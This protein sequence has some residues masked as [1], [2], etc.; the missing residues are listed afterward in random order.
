MSTETSLVAWTLAPNQLIAAEV[1]GRGGTRKEAAAAASVI[2][3]T[4]YNWLLEAEFQDAVS[5][6]FRE[7]RAEIAAKRERLIDRAMEIERESLAA[8]SKLSPEQRAQLA[9]DILARTQYR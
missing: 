2:P 4:V 8:D 9:H 5:E 7:W 3:R 6:F 1:L